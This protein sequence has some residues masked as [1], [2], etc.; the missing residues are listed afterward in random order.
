MRSLLYPCLFCVDG[1]VAHGQG[2]TGRFGR[3]TWWLL[4][5]SERVEELSDS[6]SMAV[7]E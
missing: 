6:E 4:V 1:M 3:P 7:D 5:E 2:G